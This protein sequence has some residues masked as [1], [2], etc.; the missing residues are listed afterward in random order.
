MK[1]LGSLPMGNC[2]FWIESVFYIAFN[3][4]CNFGYLCD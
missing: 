2:D 4:L 3:N 1:F